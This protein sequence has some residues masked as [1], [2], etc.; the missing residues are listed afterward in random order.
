MNFFLMGRCSS[1]GWVRE[2]KNGMSDQ[3]TVCLGVCNV[4]IRKFLMGAKRGSFSRCFGLRAL[5]SRDSNFF[6]WHRC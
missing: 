4:K 1:C 3:Y 2:V 5:V 6:S